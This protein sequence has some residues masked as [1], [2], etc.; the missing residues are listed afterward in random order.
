MQ[1]QHLLFEKKDG[2]ATITLNRPKA[3]NALT[4]TLLEEL[5]GLCV[6]L[7]SDSEVGAVIITGGEKAFAAGADLND[8]ANLGSPVDAHALEV[9][10]SEIFNRL[11]SLRQ[12]TIAAISG[13]ALGGGCELALACDVRI[14]ADT[15]KFGQPEI[16][17]GLLP[18]QGG[19]Q[20]LPRLI[21]EG[22]AKELLFGGDIIDAK[23][24]LR[25]GLVNRVVPAE[26]LL[27][28]ARATALKFAMQPRFALGMIKTLVNEGMSMDL[29]SAL[30]FEGRCFESLFGTEDQKEGV[31]AFI[32]KRK[33]HFTG[34]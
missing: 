18:G 31:K 22:R 12:P 11:A 4:Q 19:T 30:A 20:R 34:R 16:K 24:A 27:E 1:L 28:E 3:L 8:I 29:K 26:N 21:G 15:A 33:P 25:I 7:D 23:E 13:F 5:Y 10:D 2:I 14:A 9:R 17:L 32:E 6:N